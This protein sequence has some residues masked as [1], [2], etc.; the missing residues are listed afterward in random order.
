MANP[1]LDRVLPA[2]LAERAQVIDI[3]GKVGDFERL[4]SI[5]ERD[6]GALESDQS[7]RAWRDAEV[8]VSLEFRW[9]DARRALPAARGHVSAE[10]ATVCQRCLEGFRLAV[11]APVN[12]IFVRPGGEA[13]ADGA[14]DAETWELDDDMLSLA[15]LVEESLVM[16]LPLAPLHASADDCGP[17][18]GSIP[19]T[20]PDVVRPFADLKAQ[21]E[22]ANK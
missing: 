10:I 15:E 20:G 12:A 6:L 4:T 18:A 3:K 2:E 8:S 13:T 5:I 9:L 17:L 19:A 14:P 16:A 11:A 22:K 7:P 21:M 1:L